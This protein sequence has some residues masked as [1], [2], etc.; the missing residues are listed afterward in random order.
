[1]YSMPGPT[2]LHVVGYNWYRVVKSIFIKVPV[3]DSSFITL[4]VNRSSGDPSC[5]A[6]HV[7]MQYG[8]ATCTMYV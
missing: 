3:H 5:N 4:S 6:V 8:P 2:E 1:M 7:N